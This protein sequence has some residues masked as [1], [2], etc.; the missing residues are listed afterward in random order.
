MIPQSIQLH[1]LQNPR[2]LNMPLFMSTKTYPHSSGF[3]CTFRQWRARSHCR[4]L[5]GYALKFQFTFTAP[6]LDENG[7]VVDFGSLKPL[8]DRIESQFD[9]TTVVAADDP[10]LHPTFHALRT[11]GLIQLRIMEEGVG[12]EKF[13]QWGLITAEGI[14]QMQTNGRASCWS[15][16]VWEHEGNSAKIVS[17]NV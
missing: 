2:R 16:E 14:V 8:K 4:F 7:W 17:D 3:S 13:A 10:D 11:A 15:C 9:H 5:H 1:L 6:Y 12:I